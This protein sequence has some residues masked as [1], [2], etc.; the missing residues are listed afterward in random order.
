MIG[1]KN[2]FFLF[3][4]YE[5]EASFL[6]MLNKNRN[7]LLLCS[8]FNLHFLIVTLM[9]IVNFKFMK[10][11]VL[12]II[13]LINVTAFAQND[14]VAKKE[15]VVPVE[16]K[17][18][19][20]KEFPNQVAIWQMEYRGEDRTQMMFETNVV[21]QK[22]FAIVYYDKLGDLKAVEVEIHTRELPE[23][24]LNYMEKNFPTQTI[25]RVVKIYENKK[26]NITFEVGIRQKG[27]LVDLVFDASG[28]FLKRVEKN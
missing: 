22:R 20:E 21:F 14:E 11:L 6:I 23:T 5:K 10:K 25:F 19:F 1:N 7:S 15:V 16:V 3:M 28:N 18:A 24:A 2:S 8:S 13:I 9:L 27:K 12:L 26:T 17:L 4:I